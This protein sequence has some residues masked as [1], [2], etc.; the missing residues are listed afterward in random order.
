MQVSGS[1]HFED[2][3]RL[4][5]TARAIKRPHLHFSQSICVQDTALLPSSSFFANPLAAGGSADDDG[6]V[7]VSRE[8]D[9]GAGVSGFPFSFSPILGVSRNSGVQYYNK[10]TGQ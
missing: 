3:A 8:G 1:D 4:T 10:D 2:V 6:V 7:A 5:N 9:D